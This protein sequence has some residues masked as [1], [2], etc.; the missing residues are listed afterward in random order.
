MTI[1]E[2]EIIVTAKVEEALKEFKKI[3]PTVKKMMQDTQN[4]FQKM[5]TNVIKNKVSR[6]IQEVRDKISLLKKSSKDNNIKLAVSNE[7]AKKQITQLEKEIESLQ[8]KISAGEIKLQITNSAIDKTKYETRGQ[9]KRENP[10]LSTSQVNNR[11]DL[12][13]DSDSS[14]NSLIKQSDRL[15]TEVIKYAALL[16][17]AKSKLTNLKQEVGETAGIQNKLASFFTTFKSKL[18]QAKI[19]AKNLGD[20]F[21]KIPNIARNILNSSKNIGNNLKNGAKSVAKYALAL[22]SLRGIYSVLS[23]CTSSWLSSQ[24]AGAKQLSANIEYMKYAMGS[25]LAPVI[26]FVT[27]LVYKLMKAIQSIVYALTGVNIFAKASA[28]SYASMASSAKKAKKET[29]SLAG[30]HDE[31]NNVQTQENNGSDSNLAPSFDL[32]VMDVQANSFIEK[33]KNK[34]KELFQPIKA[35]WATYGAGI[36]ESMKISFDSVKTLVENIGE[37]LKTVWTNGTGQETVNI[38][39]QTCTS[40]FNII[41]NI[42]SAFSNAW[43]SG[44]VGTIII[45]NLWNALNNVLTV[46]LSVQQTFEAWTASES[47]QIFASAIIGIC[48][49]LSSWFEQITLKLKDIWEN[50]GKQTFTK[51]LE[52]ISKLTEAVDAVLK[53][54]DPV[55]NWVLEVVTPI[56]QGLIVVIG[57]VIDALSGVLDFIIGVFTGDWSRAWDGIKSIFVGIWNAIKTII[58]TV[59]NAIVSIIVGFIV[60]VKNS[61]HQTLNAIAGIWFS[62]WNRIKNVV[63]NVW[64]A[65]WGCIKGVINSIL[66]GIESFVNGTIRGINILLSGISKI[67]SAVGSL[68]GLG[69]VNLQLSTISLPR[70]AKGNV[71]YSETVAV[72]GEYSGASHN[73]EITAPQ[74]IMRETFEDVLSNYKASGNERP[75]RV[76]VYFGAKEIIDEVIDG[77]NEKTRQ[78][79]KAQIKVCYE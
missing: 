14:Y 31:I 4:S 39:L 29:Q 71:A 48:Q 6:A 25:A 30:I 67:A 9:I 42:A 77:I 64:N 45:Q 58:S 44:D 36:I 34:L 46:I 53:Y 18:D 1:E 10:S 43:T 49:T 75:V 35:S 12:K 47:F 52:F 66:G 78:T 69:P 51:L 63:S 21:K 72:F 16:E 33:L 74:S 76:Q 32:S 5:D 22:F 27:N 15:N 68:I 20:N 73:P 41:S 50:G 17:S 62:V 56:I 24:N 55:I 59:W 26:Q 7:E 13:L 65:I 40:L 23:N 60:G 2:L 8:K 70:L 19:S 79:G 11:A 37:S 54:L 38:L 28:N 3:A 61:I 57:Y